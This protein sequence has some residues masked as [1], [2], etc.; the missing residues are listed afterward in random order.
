MLKTIQIIIITPTCRLTRSE[1]AIP[2]KARGNVLGILDIQSTE[3][4]AFHQDDIDVLQT[5]ADQIGLAIQNARLFTESQ[6]AIQRLEM[7][8]SENIRQVWRERVRLNKHSY[9]YTSMGLTSATQ[10]GNMP[11]NADIASD[12]LN[13]P[14]TLRG[15]TL[16]TI[17]LH[18]KTEKAWSETDRSLAMEIASQVGLALENARLLD[19][20]QRRAAQE[21]SLSKLTANLGISL[22]P[23]TILQTAIRELHQLPNV[24]EVSAYISSP[25]PSKDESSKSS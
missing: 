9:R 15:Q 16:G 18:R 25:Q 7:S 19:E 24:A 17:V 20:A 4:S 22:D 1:A 14:I 3:P 6:D 13:I 11:T 5:M 21:Q 10:P 2:L 23:E 8:T 12:R